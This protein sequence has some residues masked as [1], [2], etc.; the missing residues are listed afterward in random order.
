MN[1][2]TLSKIFGLDLEILYLLLEKEN[3][4]ISLSDISRNLQMNKMTVRRS[5]EKILKAGLV[6]EKDDGYRRFFKLK[7][8]YV[9]Q[10]LRSL[11]NIDSKLIKRIVR[12]LRNDVEILLLYGSRADG[13]NLSDSDWDLLVVSDELDPISLNKLSNQLEIRFGQEVNFHLYTKQE[14]LSL[15]NE[16]SP[17]W[18]EISKK[19]VPLVGDIDD[20]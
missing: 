6:K 11:K 20:L 2:T 17:F 8:T 3:E 9:I 5:L 4:W 12:D 15:R 10:T 19:K 18:M 13:S 14:V 7:R 1:D 16:N